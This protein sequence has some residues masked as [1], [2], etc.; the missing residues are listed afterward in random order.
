MVA[1]LVEQQAGIP[2]LLQPLRG[3][4]SAGTV[5]GQVGRDHMAHLHTTSSPTDLVADSALYNAANRHKRAETRLPWSTRVPATVT[6][7][8]EVLAQTQP[9]TMASRPHG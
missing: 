5:C 6:A 4:R 2:L 1:L 8:Q 9:A 3:K 7:A